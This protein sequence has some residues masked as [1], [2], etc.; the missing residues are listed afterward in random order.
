M[1]FQLMLTAGQSVFGVSGMEF[2]M[3]LWFWNHWP[4]NSN[5]NGLLFLRNS[6][7]HKFNNVSWHSTRNFPQFTTLRY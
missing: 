6:F 4:K 3:P 2:Q 5:E 1:V 7:V